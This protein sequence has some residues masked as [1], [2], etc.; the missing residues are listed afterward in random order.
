ME[1]ARFPLTL[2]LSLGEREGVIQSGRIIPRSAFGTRPK[3]ELPLPKGE[4]GGEGEGSV[5]VVPRVRRGPDGCE[6]FRPDGHKTPR[7]R[8]PDRNWPAPA[9]RNERTTPTHG[10]NGRAGAL[11]G[12]RFWSGSI[13][14]DFETSTAC[15]QSLCPRLQ[16]STVSAQR[17]WSRQSSGALGQASASRKRQ[18]TAAL[19]DAGAQEPAPR[20]FM[21]REEVRKEHGASHESPSPE[22]H[23]FA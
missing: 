23:H 15:R 17:S 21:A 4:G 20:G 3:P 11:C 13:S 8:C 22:G 14:P 1:R 16:S 19:Q 12:G 10:A 6:S 5:G 7:H 18:R 9:T 2:T